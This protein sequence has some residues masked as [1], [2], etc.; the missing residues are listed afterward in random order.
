MCI[1]DGSA[2]ASSGESQRGTDDT[3]VYTDE[4]SMYSAVLNNANGQNT[5]V[6]SSVSNLFCRRDV[7]KH[8]SN[9]ERVLSKQNDFDRLKD[10]SAS[11]KSPESISMGTFINTDIGRPSKS[12]VS[13]HK[14][15]DRAL[16]MT[17][18]EGH[19]HKHGNTA[20]DYEMIGNSNMEYKRSLNSDQRR[21]SDNEH[22][23]KKASGQIS[24]NITKAGL[25]SLSYSAVW[26]SSA[27]ESDNC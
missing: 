4:S 20:H 26:H 1:I 14:S 3:G 12:S 23:G 18:P 25:S 13:H 27:P 17:D 8:T 11:E 22:S 7:D 21:C 2:N 19:M 10:C 24:E 16:A 5:L 15:S 9:G 6:R